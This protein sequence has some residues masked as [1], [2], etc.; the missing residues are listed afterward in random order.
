MHRRLRASGL[1]CAVLVMSIA[2]MAARAEAAPLTG[3]LAFTPTMTATPMPEPGSMMLLGTGLF[4]LAA[5][6]RERM[7]S[8]SR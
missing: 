1:H 8:I 2:G 6:A 7:R 5:A 3:S 4:G